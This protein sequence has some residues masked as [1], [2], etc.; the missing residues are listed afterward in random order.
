MT[1]CY[2][3]VLGSF[4]TFLQEFEEQHADAPPPSSYPIYHPATKILQTNPTLTTL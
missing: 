1:L 2:I 3:I 4:L